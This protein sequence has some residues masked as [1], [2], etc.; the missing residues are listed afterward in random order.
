[1]KRDVS[2]GRRALS[3]Q[4]TAWIILCQAAERLSGG[5]RIGRT[6]VDE[7]R[8][9]EVKEGRSE[10]GERGTEWRRE[11]DGEGDSRILCE[12]VLATN[13][14]PT[15]VEHS[16]AGDVDHDG[17]FRGPYEEYSQRSS[18]FL[19][20][21]TAIP[22]SRVSNEQ[23]R[24][25]TASPNILE[26]PRPRTECVAPFSSMGAMEC[27]DAKRTIGRE[28]RTSGLQADAGSG[29]TEDDHVLLGLQATCRR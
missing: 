17:V 24:R 21:L 23:R 15:V 5:Y 16:A 27:V 13:E 7:G 28:Q 11:E 18:T 3:G 12:H 6:L 19:W 9:E 14:T 20:A 4:R 8:S 25:R 2:S 22:G 1:M 29:H 26:Q 10:A